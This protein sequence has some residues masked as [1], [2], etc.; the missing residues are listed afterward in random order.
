M[1]NQV[2]SK[3]PRCAGERMFLDLTMETPQIGTFALSGT[4]PKIQIQAIPRLKCAN[5]T[6]SMTGKIEEGYAVFG[7]S[8]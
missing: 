8:R 7:G 3:C 6:W 5:C 1:S 4:Q 2:N